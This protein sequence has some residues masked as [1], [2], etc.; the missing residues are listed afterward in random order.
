VRDATRARPKIERWWEDWPK[1]NIGAATGS[2]DILALEVDANA[3]G[4]D[5]W[6]QW[7]EEH[8]EVVEGRIATNGTGGLVFFFRAPV[9]NAVPSRRNVKPGVHIC[10]EGG[11]V[12]LPPSVIDHAM[13]WRVDPD[14]APPEYM[15]T[16]VEDYARLVPEHPPSERGFSAEVREWDHQTV[17]ESV[18]SV[19]EA[20]ASAHQQMLFNRDG[21]LS[22]IKGGDPDKIDLEVAGLLYELGVTDPRDIAFGLMASRFKDPDAWYRVKAKPPTYFANTVRRAIGQVDAARAAADKLKRE[23]HPA[24]QKDFP[25]TEMGDTDRLLEIHPGELVYHSLERRW[26]VWDGACFSG[27]ED[28]RGGAMGIDNRVGQY[29]RDLPIVSQLQPYAEGQEDWFKYAMRS[30]TAGHQ[31]AMK[32]LARSACAKGELELDPDPFLLNCTN[33]VADLRDGTLS[34]HSKSYLMTRVAGAPYMPGHTSELWQAFLERSLPDKLERDFFGLCMGYSIL[35]T[36]SQQRFFFAWGPTGTGKS[37]AL[38]AIRAALGG[39]HRAADFST[40]LVQP[41]KQSSAPSSD[42]ARLARTRLVSAIEVDAGQQLNTGLIKQLSGG[43]TV[44]A[45]K[46][47]GDETEYRPTMALWFVA[48]DRPKGRVEDDAL[49]RRLVPFHFNEPLAED[50]MDRTLDAKLEAPLERAGILSWLIA[51]AQRYLELGRL[52]LPES[53]RAGVLAYKDH[54]NPISEWVNEVVVLDPIARCEQPAMWKAYREWCADNNEKGIRKGTFRSIM[55]D[56]SSG[57]VK[58]QGGTLCWQGVRL[59]WTGGDSSPG[60]PPELDR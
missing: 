39:H 50:D 8:D 33:G 60:T 54:S 26:Y 46:L 7:Q 48:N 22:L 51:N 53:V 16:W 38:F 49:W 30:Q 19:L 2:G 14:T 4:F 41:G 57:T 27:D 43:D 11:F 42:L 21:R 18:V 5:S 40:F 17:P 3:G 6:E 13:V 37:T 34:P 47:Y 32:Q 9:K 15:P 44:T 31:N 28:R 59:G 12:P 56:L 20:T 36:Q 10:G 23:T 1:A 29:L 52:E 24:W 55:D 45:R 25:M 58:S 35:G